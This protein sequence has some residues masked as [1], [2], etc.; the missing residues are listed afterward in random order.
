MHHCWKRALLEEY[1]SQVLEKNLQNSIHF[2][3]FI[4]DQLRNEIVASS[5]ICLF[6]SY[7]EPFGIVALEAM[8]AG[9]TDNR[10]RIAD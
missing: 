10:L 1:R 8:V 2:I 3:G 5:H 7:Y 4:D 6:P 9:K